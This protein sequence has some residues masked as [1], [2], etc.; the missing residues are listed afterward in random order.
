ME[1]HGQFQDH[2]DDDQILPGAGGLRTLLLSQVQQGL[3]IKMGVEYWRASAAHLQRGHCTGS[4]M[5]SG[6]FVPWSSL[7]YS[8][9]WKL[10]HYMAKRVTLGPVIVTAFQNKEDELEIWVVNDQHQAQNMSSC[11]PAD[12][13]FCGKDP[14]KKRSTPG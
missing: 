4:S 13:G 11:H 8:G 9:R 12:M 7:E 3:A 5:M 2:G 10:L 6:R 1:S 14:K